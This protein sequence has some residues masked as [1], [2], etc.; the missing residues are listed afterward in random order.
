MKHSQIVE[1]ARVLLETVNSDDMGVLTA[2]LSVDGKINMAAHASEQ[3]SVAI[4]SIL[5]EKILEDN[6]CCH[7]H[8]M[9]TAMAIRE[10]ISNI[11]AQ[12]FEEVGKDE[13]TKH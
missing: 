11:V 13:E 4:I 9:T 2:T 10:T 1:E 3:F 6:M 5:V 12:K 8:F 7:A